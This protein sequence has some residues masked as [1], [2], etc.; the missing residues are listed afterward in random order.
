[1][2][3]C[4]D[5]MQTAHIF[6]HLALRL[7][8][9]NPTFS[10]LNSS[11]VNLA[12]SPSHRRL[13]MVSFTTRS[14]KNAEAKYQLQSALEEYDQN[15]NK[16]TG[17][18]SSTDYA[19]TPSN[20]VVE[21]DN[22][23]TAAAETDN[24][25]DRII[26]MWGEEI[27]CDFGMQSAREQALEVEAAAEAEAA[28]KAELEQLKQE[29]KR[30]S[31]RKKRKKRKQAADQAKEVEVEV[32]YV[33]EAKLARDLDV[34]AADAKVKQRV[35]ARKAAEA[36]QR[37]ALIEAAQAKKASEG[38]AQQAAAARRQLKRATEAMKMAKMEA[39]KAK[40]L[41]KKEAKQAK[42]AEKEAKRQ[43]KEEELA[44]QKYAKAQAAAA[45][46]VAME[47]ERKAAATRKL[48]QQMEDEESQLR[49]K[50]EK[51]RSLRQRLK[52]AS[53]DGDLAVAG[54]LKDFETVVSVSDEDDCSTVYTVDD[55]EE[56]RAG[57][58]QVLSDMLE[59]ASILLGN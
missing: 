58:T 25:F 36:R 34:E 52:A 44:R 13:T 20:M 24:I 30:T 9:T 42:R 2:A 53:T 38:P 57:I 6:L 12:P 40:M 3:F 10:L 37:Q 55:E 31:N 22:Y 14:T 27:S 15:N 23:G 39:K 43:A 5:G 19:D 54:G 46:K 45:K 26:N 33:E 51:I 18:T 47:E 50:E 29:K 8:L 41:A 48:L 16:M 1:M 21:V 32:T 56:S 11:Q 49:E 17:H 28:A 4:L 59:E 35:Q 7:Q